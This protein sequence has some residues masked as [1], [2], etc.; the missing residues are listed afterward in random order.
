MIKIKSKS[1]EIKEVEAVGR[2]AF[3]RRS[4]SKENRVLKTAEHRNHSNDY[5][6]HSHHFQNQV[7]NIKAR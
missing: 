4:G 7:A 1:R 6:P 5:L 2:H 3:S